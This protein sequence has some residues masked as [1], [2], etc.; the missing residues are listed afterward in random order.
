MQPTRYLRG[1]RA[2]TVIEMLAVIAAGACLLVLLTLWL[3]RARHDAR[4]TG[5]LSLGR[6][7]FTLLVADDMDRFAAGSNSSAPPAPRV[8]R[9]ASSTDYFNKM[10]QQGKLDVDLMIFSAPGIP[11]ATGS[12][13]T[14]ENNAWKVTLDVND[15]SP[16]L[17]PVMF[18]RNI[19]TP[20]YRLK[21]GNDHHLIA[22]EKPFGNTGAIAIQYAGSTLKLTPSTM[23]LFNPSGASNAV[24]VP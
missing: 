14:A 11:P 20:G 12:V 7:I 17:L 19:D 6:Q 15:A 9:Y 23:K 5:T 1:R 13:M 4:I 18:T 24:L 2:F 21:P 8:S 22:S 10:K 16:S 3:S